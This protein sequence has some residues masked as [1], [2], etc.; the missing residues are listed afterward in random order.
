MVTESIGKSLFSEHQSEQNPDQPLANFGTR[1]ASFDPV[2]LAK[3]LDGN[4]GG[5]AETFS[6]FRG[7]RQDQIPLGRGGV[8]GNQSIFA[9]LTLSQ[10]SDRVDTRFVGVAK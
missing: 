2:Q 4:T 10:Q 6:D 8:I 5:V 3:L 7:R 9:D 1:F